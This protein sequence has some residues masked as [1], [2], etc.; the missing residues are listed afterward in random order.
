MSYDVLL[1]VGVVCRPYLFLISATSPATGTA[2]ASSDLSFSR[3]SLDLSSLR[4][5]YGDFDVLRST[6]PRLAGQSGAEYS[7]TCIVSIDL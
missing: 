6:H 7:F 3:Y 5:Q 2:L 1:V 4:Y